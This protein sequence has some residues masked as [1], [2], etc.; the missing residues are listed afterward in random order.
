MYCYKCGVE[1]A[2][3]QKNC[4]L[5]G[6]KVP[7][8]AVDAESTY[9]E[10]D[11]ILNHPM[12]LRER[13]TLASMIISLLLI[14]PVLLVLV[15]DLRENA[16]IDWSLIPI[17]SILLSWIIICLPLIMRRSFWILYPVYTVSISVFFLLLDYNTGFSGWSW[18]LAIP[19][20]FS[21]VTLLFLTVFYGL[22]SKHKGLNLISAILLFV[23]LCSTC[24]D[25]LVKLFMEET[26]VP[27]WSLI[28]V[29]T[30]LPVAWFL[31]Y[32]HR[33]PGMRATLRKKFHV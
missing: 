10:L 18:R 16:R 8:D 1:L 30:A 6:T 32:L 33:N 20:V 5:C 29:I 2:E 22:K 31:T 19:L 7:G 15:I 4:P 28:V 9:P 27:G 3:D 26:A 17:I 25:I 24:I 12:N 21:I 11:P 13:Q 14:I 23:G